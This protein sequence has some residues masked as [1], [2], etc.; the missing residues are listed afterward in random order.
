MRP[1]VVIS[2][3][4]FSGIGLLT[5]FFARPDR[6]ESGAALPLP[7]TAPMAATAGD[8][9]T[10]SMI[11]ISPPATR[12]V[13][14]LTEVASDQQIQEE[15]VSKRVAELMELAMTDDTD[16]LHLI[17]SELN[18]NDPRIREAAVTASVQ[19]KSLEAIPALQNA[20]S[21]F[22]DPKEKIRIAE[23]I[24]FLATPLESQATAQPN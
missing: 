2:I 4:L 14:L 3:L 6:R 1:Q 5:I 21:R 19:F 7:E 24:E 10:A 15:Y 17:L 22:D 11:E 18:N 23:A 9:E 13:T 8:A 12:P 20:Y 16:S